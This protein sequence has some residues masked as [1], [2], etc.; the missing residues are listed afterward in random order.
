MTNKLSKNELHKGLVKVEKV[1][2]VKKKQQNLIVIFYLILIT[3]YILV[4]Y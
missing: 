3:K 2:K 1:E 4:T